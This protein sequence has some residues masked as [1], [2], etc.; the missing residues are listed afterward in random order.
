MVNNEPEVKKRRTRGKS[1]KPT[2]ILT[3]IRLPKYVIDYFKHVHPNERHAKM[4]AALEEYV[5]NEL[6]QQGLGND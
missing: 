1:K 6:K 4:R 2:L 3:S 5:I